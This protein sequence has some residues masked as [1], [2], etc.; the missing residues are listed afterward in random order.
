MKNSLFLFLFFTTF[1]ISNL[2]LAESWG[3]L[4]QKEGN[5]QGQVCVVYDERNECQVDDV[6][7]ET[8]IEL[9]EHINLRATPNNGSHFVQ[10]VGDCRGRNPT[11]RLLSKKPHNDK[12]LTATAVFALGPAAPI[13]KPV[14]SAKKV[15]KKIKVI[16]KKNTKKIQK[17]SRARLK[18]NPSKSITIALITP[19]IA[20]R[21]RIAASP[22]FYFFFE[23]FKIS[24]Y[25]IINK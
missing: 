4:L 8:N 25:L 11:C 24:S 13:N 20:T 5:G 14:I 22:I 23:T 19:F 18:L 9:N 7:T 21:E 17:K 1:T 2:A 15:T 10:W 12:P 6:G 16:S 3:L